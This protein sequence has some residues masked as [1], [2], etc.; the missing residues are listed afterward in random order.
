MCSNAT[1][2]VVAVRVVGSTSKAVVSTSPRSD[3]GDSQLILCILQLTRK[4]DDVGIDLTRLHV[5]FLFRARLLPFQSFL[6]ARIEGYFRLLY[7]IFEFFP[8]QMRFLREMLMLRNILLQVFNKLLYLL[9][10]TP[11][12]SLYLF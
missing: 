5:Q 10:Q 4:R 7:D 8:L 2:E 12:P 1:L 3:V 9:A 11:R 6:V